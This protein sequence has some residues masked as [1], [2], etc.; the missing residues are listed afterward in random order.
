MTVAFMTVAVN[1]L[2]ATA[3]MAEPIP[4]PAPGSVSAPWI[5]RVFIV[6]SDVS[7]EKAVH[8][9][10][11]DDAEVGSALVVGPWL[12]GDWSFPQCVPDQRIRASQAKH[13]LADFFNHPS[14][15]GA[16]WF[17][18]FD[19][20]SSK[21]QANRGL[22]RADGQPWQTLVRELTELHGRIRQYM[23]ANVE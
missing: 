3:L 1:G 7:P 17:T 20:D 5:E 13:I 9:R 21:R 4:L 22:V 14:V 12:A 6:E 16:H 19:P 10:I 18:Y 15:V 11:V 23:S 2:V 8:T